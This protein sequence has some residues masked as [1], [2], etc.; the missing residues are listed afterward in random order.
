MDSQIEP[1]ELSSTECLRINGFKAFYF[2]M[3][4]FIEQVATARLDGTYTKLLN[5]IAKTPLLV[6]DDFGLQPLDIPMQLTLHQIMEDRYKKFPV[7]ITSQLP[8]KEWHAYIGEATI[9]DSILDRLT[10]NDH[11]IDL[12]GPSLRKK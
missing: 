6:L 11:R 4:R 3:S 2:T 9:A 12:K 5:S 8:V 10:A 7:M 1:V